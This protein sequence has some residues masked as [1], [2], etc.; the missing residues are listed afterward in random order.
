MGP[1]VSIGVL[2]AVLR[3]A[4]DRV[5]D[6]TEVR[7]DLVRLTGDEMDLQY[8]VIRAALQ[9]F[10][11][12]MDFDGVRERLRADLDA[13]RPL[14]L[15]EVAVDALS[16]VNVSTY[17]GEVILLH[18]SVT[19]QAGK[20]LQRWE[21]LAEEDEAGGVPVEAV[22]DAR[23]EGLELRLRERAGRHQVPE[24]E[25]VHRRQTGTIR[26]AEPSGWLIQHQ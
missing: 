5:A 16:V 13:V 1:V 12:G 9:W 17:D 3:V 21:G 6:G 19:E 11:R 15:R 4:D 8:R 23:L 18:R 20:G 14:V 22:R 25:L 10:V 7:A 2:P 26:L 24:A